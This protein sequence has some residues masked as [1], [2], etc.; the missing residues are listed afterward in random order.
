MTLIC[1]SAAPWLAV[2]LAGCSGKVVN[3]DDPQS[4][5]DDAQDDIKSDR[6]LVALEKLRKLRHKFPYSKFS[7]KAQLRIADVYFLQESFSDAAQ[8]YE[9]FRDLH[10]K[11][12]DTPY[13]TYRVG[14]SYAK[15]AP[16]NIARD[17]TSDHKAL[18]AFGEFLKLYPNDARA[19]DAKEQVHIVRNKLAAKELYIG[20]FYRI[21]SFPDAAAPRYKRV[22]ELYPDTDSAADAKKYVAELEKK[23][24]KK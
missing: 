21:R 9:S 7:S 2:N 12:E 3:E 4:I 23:A 5:Y 20:D 11:H 18:T 24:A 6:Y 10:P 16:E 19:K 1:L 17:L 8:E 15:D 14:E 13:A 22:L